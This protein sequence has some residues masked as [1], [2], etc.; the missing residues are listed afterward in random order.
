MNDF[1]EYLVTFKNGTTLIMTKSYLFNCYIN[2]I[3]ESVADYEL[4]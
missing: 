1:T 3:D 2:T 4:A